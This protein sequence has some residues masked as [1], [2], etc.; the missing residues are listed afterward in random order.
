MAVPSLHPSID[1]EGIDLDEYD[2]VQTG[3]NSWFLDLTLLE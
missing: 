2:W 1:A 3:E